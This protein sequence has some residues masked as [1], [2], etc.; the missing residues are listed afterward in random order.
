MGVPY[1]VILSACVLMLAL[2]LLA[3]SPNGVLNGIVVDASNSAIVGADVI[4]QNDTTGVQYSTKTNGEG[5]FVLPNLPPRGLSPSSLEV[6][7]QIHPQ[8]GHRGARARRPGPEFHLAGWH[9]LGSS[10]CDWRCAP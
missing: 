9:D 5:I 10:H 8:A 4:A 3:Q 2:P 6:R 7:I 1:V